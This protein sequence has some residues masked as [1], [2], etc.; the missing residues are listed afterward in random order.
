M[1]FWQRVA[2]ALGGP[3]KASAAVEKGV[4]GWGNSQIVARQ[5]LENPFEQYLGQYRPMHKVYAVY[6]AMREAIPLIDVALRKRARRV[7]GIR[8]DGMGDHGVQKVLDQV[9]NTRV[10]WMQRGMNTLIEQVV[11]ASLFKGHAIFEVVPKGG[12]DGFNRFVVGRP[13]NFMMQTKQNGEPVIV[14]ETGPG[15]YEAMPRQDLLFWQVFGTVEGGY[16]GK[17]L[18]SSCPF[19]ANIVVRILT[20]VDAVIWRFGDPT[21]LS[22]LKGGTAGEIAKVGK[23]AAQYGQE[24]SKAM[25]ARKIGQTYDVNVGVPADG[26]FSVILLGADSKPMEISVD[27]KLAMEQIISASE[28]APWEFGLSWA[29]TERLAKEQNEAAI[30]VIEGNRLALEPHIEKVVDM[31]LIMAGRGGA[32]WRMEWE[33]LNLSDETAK[34][35]ARL[36]T[37]QAVAREMQSAIMMHDVGIMDDDE[38]IAFGI[39]SG[40]VSED[41]LSGSNEA[42]VF[43]VQQAVNQKRAMAAA[44]VAMVGF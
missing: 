4:D 32:R 41:Q 42:K 38:L 40:Y 16:Y 1:A 10:G 20:A 24:I 25:G 22:V 3:G 35:D 31:A 39:R 6:D 11:D 17:P 12:V 36:K 15:A 29:T 2:G 9:Y 33:P 28:L 30:S 44:K 5:K 7:A 37:A 23:A 14:Q 19:V 34:A 8:L 27:Y 13:D 43:A 26:E 18:F 21:I